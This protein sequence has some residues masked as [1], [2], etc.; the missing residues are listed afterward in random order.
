MM[1]V[2]N[3]LW[4]AVKLTAL[5]VVGYTA[6]MIGGCLLFGGIGALL[7]GIVYGPAYLYDRL[8]N[9]PPCYYMWWGM[10]DIK[11]KPGLDIPQYLQANQESMDRL[12]AFDIYWYYQR[13]ETKQ[14]IDG[15]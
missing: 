9:H 4:N 2:V 13:L 8:P 12:T 11:C 7:V 1:Y 5:A 3:K 10:G 6:I 15:M 14:L